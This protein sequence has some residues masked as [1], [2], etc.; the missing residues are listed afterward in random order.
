MT[1]VKTKSTAQHYETNIA[2]LY[3]AGCDIGDYG[4]SCHMFVPMLMAACTYVDKEVSKFMSKFL[5]H[6]R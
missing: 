5:H 6:W 3:A 1:V 4:H 2:Q